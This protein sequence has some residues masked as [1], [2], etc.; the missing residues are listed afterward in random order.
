MK[1]IRAFLHLVIDWKHMLGLEFCD[2]WIF[3]ELTVVLLSTGGVF[4][5][6]AE[7]TFHPGNEKLIIIQQFKGIDEHDHLLISTELDGRIP[8]IPRGA[9]VQVEPYNEIY[10]YSSN[11]TCLNVHQSSSSVERS[12]EI[13]NVK[14]VSQ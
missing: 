4:T 13:S 2:V 11:C 3:L 5:R 9:T 6:Q 10:Q 12:R 8:E 7:V 14:P 1:F